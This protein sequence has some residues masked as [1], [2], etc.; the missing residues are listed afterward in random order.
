MCWTIRRR[1]GSRAAY[2]AE[3][4]VRTPSLEQ[5][6]RN[7]SGGNQQK[8]L[9]AR[10]LLTEPRVLF[11]DEPTRG[12]DVGAKVEIYDIMNDLVDR[13]VCVVMVSCE[14]PEVLG[15]SDRVLVM[16]E[17]RIAAELR[18]A[19][20]SEERVMRFATGA[21]A[22]RRLRRGRTMETRTSPEP[23]WAERRARLA[24]GSGGLAARATPGSTP[25]SWRSP[26][27][28]SSSPS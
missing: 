26:R 1:P 11:L 21:E 25:C 12:I 17:G 18:R 14:L 27:S 15:M 3:L 23:A 8:V 22:A 9:I 19:E 7:L 10:G 6:V 24:R 5:R 20:A 16:R 28:G 4:R 13:G 2:A